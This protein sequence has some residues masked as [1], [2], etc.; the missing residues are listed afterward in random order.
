[1]YSPPIPHGM[2]QTASW[3]QLPE[4]A[5]AAAYRQWSGKGQRRPG[6][7]DGYVYDFVTEQPGA[8]Y[9]GPLPFCVAAGRRRA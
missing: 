3:S 9:V 1:M 4:T 7:A 5:R 2:V 6:L 8:G